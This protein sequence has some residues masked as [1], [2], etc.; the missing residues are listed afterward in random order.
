MRILFF[1][2]VSLNL[3]AMDK[4]IY[5]EDNRE[6]SDLF[7]DVYL[8][9]LSRSVGALIPEKNLK[10]NF[11]VYK[12]QRSVKNLKDAYKFCEGEK[13]NDQPTAAI[14]TGF[15]ISS[16]IMVTAGHCYAN[17]K[18]DCKENL[19]VFDYK[20]PSIKE[21]PAEN[22]YHCKKIL[23]RKLEN[24]SGI[25][26]TVVE[27]DREVTDR[28]PLNLSQDIPTEGIPLV[29]M[30]HPLG[31]PLKIS[32][33]AEVLSIEDNFFRANLDSFEGNS[34]SPVFNR[35]NGVVEGILVRGK[36]DFFMD[37]SCR[38]ANHCDDNGENCDV[39]GAIKAEEV[40]LIS[41]IFPVISKI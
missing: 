30:G 41:N 15:L 23:G 11:D 26:Y 2:M 34:G 32:D 14:C 25:D 4:L 29:I 1:L 27:L 40:V 35:G 13:F 37:G 16:K 7:K 39:Q 17:E 18:K 28:K 12:L 3:F 6:E 20:G 10:K 36:P 5:G 19:W 9:S 21:L 22:V 38:R 31:I 24:E 33:G 8:K